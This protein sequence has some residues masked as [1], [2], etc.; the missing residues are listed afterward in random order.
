MR[1]F[2]NLASETTPI[3]PRARTACA[4]A[5]TEDVQLGGALQRDD[6]SMPPTGVEVH[7][8]REP[9]T[10]LAGDKCPR[11]R[12]TRAPWPPTPWFDP[13]PPVRRSP[14]KVDLVGCPPIE[15]SRWPVLVEPAD[16]ENEFAT[17]ILAA[18]GHGN[19]SH[20]FGFQSPY[21][22]LHDC[23]ASVLTDRTVSRRFDALAPDPLLECV[24]VKDAVAIADNVPWF[25]AG[26]SNRA[27]KECT[28]RV[29]VRV[30]LENADINDPP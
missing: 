23:N 22:P 15:P 26:P 27:A 4:V 1:I 6:R 24:T 7:C 14:A 8:D 28:D 2:G 19:S 13:W 20:A 29:A 9:I 11:H 3:G 12:A 30:L 17:K 5:Q 18:F 16:K 25:R 10:G 21:R